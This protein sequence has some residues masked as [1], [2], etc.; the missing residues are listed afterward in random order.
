MS[1]DGLRTRRLLAATPFLL[2]VSLP[3]GSSSDGVC[4]LFFLAFSFWGVASTRRAS[5]VPARASPADLDR[6]PSPVAR[7]FRFVSTPADRSGVREGGSG[8][9]LGE[10]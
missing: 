2:F 8:E 10:S 4:S 5:E 7:F 6:L 9:L 1:C 3:P